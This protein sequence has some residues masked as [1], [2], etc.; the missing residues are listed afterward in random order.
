[1]FDGTVVITGADQ[2][3]G[4]AVATDLAGE[5]ARL[6]LGG[7]DASRLSALSADLSGS[8]TAVDVLRT[9]VRDEFDLERLLETGARGDGLDTVVPCDRIA[10]TRPAA[11]LGVESYAAF[12]DLLR[13]NVRGVY[14]T[15][16]ETLGHG[17][18][19]TAIVVPVVDVE[20]AGDLF[21]LGEVTI[22]ALVEALARERDGPTVTVGLEGYPLAD[23]DDVEGP[24]ERVGLAVRSLRDGSS[25]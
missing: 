7:S 24:V 2:P 14:A 15:L 23:G 11:P 16:R 18:D 13:H 8:A 22:A 5:G 20:R 1:M 17:D 19:R 21:E 3:L 25:A 6:L 4:R 12:D 9:D 10:H